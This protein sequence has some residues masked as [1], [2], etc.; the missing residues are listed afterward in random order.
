MSGTCTWV[1]GLLFPFLRWVFGESAV[2][3][4]LQDRKVA[5]DRGNWLFFVTSY[6]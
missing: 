3:V 2:T 6:R 1:R 5:E 4:Y